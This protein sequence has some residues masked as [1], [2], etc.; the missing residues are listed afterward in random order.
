MVSPQCKQRIKQS[1]K[2]N[3]LVFFEVPG[4]YANLK[5]HQCLNAALP[6]LFQPVNLSLVQ[7]TQ[8]TPS[9]VGA[10]G[11]HWG[12]L[13]C[14]CVYFSGLEPLRLVVPCPK[15]NKGIPV[16]EQKG[17]WVMWLQTASMESCWR[18]YHPQECGIMSM[19]QFAVILKRFLFL[20]PIFEHGCKP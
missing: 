5:S 15:R 19:P 1:W 3:P 6:S 14:L 7:G 2:Q 16:R 12:M 17:H 20:R 11:W 10:E 9:V 8:F 4:P 13:A 18:T